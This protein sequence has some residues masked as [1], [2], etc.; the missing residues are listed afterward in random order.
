VQR[1]HKMSQSAQNNLVLVFIECKYTSSQVA[2]T[3]ETKSLT[4]CYDWECVFVCVLLC[5]C[6]CVSV[7]VRVCVCAPWQFDANTRNRNPPNRP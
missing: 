2:V 1:L 6:V 3:A 5:V 7:S 4:L